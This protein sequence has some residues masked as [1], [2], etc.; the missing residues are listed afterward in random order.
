MEQLDLSRTSL[1]L[2]DDIEYSRSTV[3]RALR[4]LGNPT[5]HEAANGRAALEIPS[6]TTRGIELVISDFN[7][8][9]MH[10][11]ELLKAIRTGHG[12]G[13][14]RGIPFAMLT[15]H[16]DSHLV[17][18]ALALD[19]NSFLI[20]PVSRNNLEERLASMLEQAEADDWLKSVA[21]YTEVAVASA[22]EEIPLMYSAPTT[23]KTSIRVAGG[24]TRK[25]SRQRTPPDAKQKIKGRGVVAQASVPSNAK[26]LP[27]GYRCAI[28]DLPPD[29]L[30]TR[31]VVTTNGLMLLSAGTKLQPRNVAMLTDLY[32]LGYVESIIW[33]TVSTND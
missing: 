26:K 16:S 17:E 9:E 18:L 20:K 33:I 19:V 13:L 23:G 2:V 3:I 22:L 24:V 14:K 4:T 27:R 12:N 5:I 7:M 28:I 25:T 29:A 11:L 6:V 31:D 21:N 1:L 32:K 30:L 10:G 15:G 8:P